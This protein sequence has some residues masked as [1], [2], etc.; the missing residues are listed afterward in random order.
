MQDISQIAHK[1]RTPL[2]V[3]MSTV[4]NLLDGAFGPLNKDQTEW[5]KKLENHAATLQ[6]L[7]DEVLETV[8]QVTQ[9]STS[10]VAN[11][12][13]PNT[14][15]KGRGASRTQSFLASGNTRILVV[16][17]EPDVLDVIKEGL[18]MKGFEAFT[19]SHGEEALR[20]VLEKS[21]ALILMDLHLNG[22]NGMDIC[23]QIKNTVKS[24]TPIILITGQDDLRIKISEST[25]EADDLLTKPFQMEEL[26]TRVSSMLKMKQLNDELEKYR[27]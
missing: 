21:P 15:S 6:K 24:F 16:D 8:K 12:P 9:S 3:I 17:D 2:T 14:E 18:A 10:L 13:A 4:N 22:Q 11:P 1:L 7:L 26:F 23:R 20:L 5:L 19:T 25:N 27:L